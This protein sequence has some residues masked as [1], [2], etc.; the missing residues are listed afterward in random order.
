[1]V[2]STRAPFEAVDRSVL[3]RLVRAALRDPLA[4]VL[5]QEPAVIPYH[6]VQPGRALV[7]FSGRARC[8]GAVVPWSLVLKYRHPPAPDTTASWEREAL[9]YQS[10]LLASLPGPL[11]A[12]RLLQLDDAAAGG[13]WP[14]SVWRR[15]M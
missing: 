12:P 9:A 6:A 14:P 1:M 7:R 11:V 2:K 3:T 13:R 5:D 8:G 15:G 10:G 4:T